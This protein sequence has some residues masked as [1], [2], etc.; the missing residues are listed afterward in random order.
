MQTNEPPPAES[1]DQ[2]ER[3]ISSPQTDFEE[4]KERATGGINAAMTHLKMLVNKPIGPSSIANRFS[5]SFL[6][7][8]TRVGLWDSF[9]HHCS[10]EPTMVGLEVNCLT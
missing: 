10:S 3:L 6:P 4:K 8:A 2:P 5:H 7:G 1:V 9:I